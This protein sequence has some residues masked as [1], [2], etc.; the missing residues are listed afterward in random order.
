MELMES[1]LGDGKQSCGETYK[2]G[3]ANKFTL[4]LIVRKEEKGEEGEAIVFFDHTDPRELM[5]GNRGLEGWF[6]HI[7]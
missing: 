1:Q 4:T 2:R 5:N 3:K 6:L 7:L